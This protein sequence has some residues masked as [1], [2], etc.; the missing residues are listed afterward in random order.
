V[1][2]TLLWALNSSYESFKVKYFLQKYNRIIISNFPRNL[3]IFSQFLSFFLLFFQFFKI[4]SFLGHFLTPRPLRY[5]NFLTIELD[6][7]QEY[8][9]CQQASKNSFL[10]TFFHVN[11]T[12]TLLWSFSLFWG[13]LGGSRGWAL[14]WGVPRRLHM[15]PNFSI[16]AHTS[17]SYNW[18]IFRYKNGYKRRKISC[19][20]KIIP[21]TSILSDFDPFMGSQQFLCI[22]KS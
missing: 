10:T 20:V 15:V 18:I 1:I 4:W 11:S 19:S 7:S 2:L 14:T 12:K 6:L 9:R 22:H 3:I 21:K 8:L 17:F 5:P 16:L 13:I